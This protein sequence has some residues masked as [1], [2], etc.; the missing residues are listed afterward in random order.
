M[1]IEVKQLIIKSTVTTAPVNEQRPQIQSIDIRQL[2]EMLLR[3]CQELIRDR[4][5]EARER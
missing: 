4:L 5:D 1:T 2:R 3:E